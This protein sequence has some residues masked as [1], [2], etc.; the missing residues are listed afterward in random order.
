MLVA[1][2]VRR[3]FLKLSDTEKREEILYRFKVE[4]N[5]EIDIFT[6][7]SFAKPVDSYSGKLSKE[8]FPFVII[9]VN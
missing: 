1:I 7:V 6:F 9:Y 4:N 5:K 8:A 2:R 3:D